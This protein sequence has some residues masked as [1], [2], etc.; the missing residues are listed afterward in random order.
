MKIII[1]P[2][3]IMLQITCAVFCI[4]IIA[5]SCMVPKLSSPDLT[6][7]NMRAMVSCWEHI[8]KPTGHSNIL[9][10]INS[11]SSTQT[12]P[13]IIDNEILHHI[14]EDGK[15]FYPSSWKNGEFFDAWGQPIIITLTT[16]NNGKV[17]LFMHSFGKN[18]RN[19]NGKGDD[20][21]MWF[22]AD[23]FYSTFNGE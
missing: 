16:N 19:E 4:T 20:V 8:M 5:R 13:R 15:I 2:L 1:S 3:R 12:I 21:I 10:Y 22:D 23:M 6:R 9:E 18:K 14:I 17:G 11:K 7:A